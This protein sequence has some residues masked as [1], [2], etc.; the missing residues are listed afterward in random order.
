MVRDAASIARESIRVCTIF[1]QWSRQLGDDIRT[2]GMSAMILLK[3]VD[4][5]RD[6][7]TDGQANFEIIQNSQSLFT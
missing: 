6:S 1:T 5:L 4:K 7:F 2:E 3:Y